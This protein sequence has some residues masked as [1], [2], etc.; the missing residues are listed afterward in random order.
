MAD[1]LQDWMKSETWKDVAL[2]ALLGPFDSEQAYEASLRL[3]NLYRLQKASKKSS[4]APPKC[5]T[6]AAAPAL[7]PQHDT[8]M[9]R[10]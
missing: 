9:R 2:L 10:R 1:L 8:M 4:I 5:F 7:S 6:C 3:I